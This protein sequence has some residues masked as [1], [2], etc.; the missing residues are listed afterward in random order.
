MSPPF[1]KGN[2]E[3]PGSSDIEMDTPPQYPNILEW[4]QQ[5]TLDVGRNH[6]GIDYTQHVE[7]FRQNGIDSLADMALIS[8]E[9][10][11]TLG[12]NL[13]LA[14]CLL[15][16]SVDYREKLVQKKKRAKLY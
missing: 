6:D 2:Q 5:L 16:W 1:R 15:K 4:L 11:R 13:G 8:V 3:P 12:F 7:V 14:N 9:Q 10:L